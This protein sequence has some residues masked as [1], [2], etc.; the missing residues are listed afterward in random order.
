MKIN[1]TIKR[2]SLMFVCFS[3]IVFWIIGLQ[4]M[5][6]EPS[7]RASIMTIDEVVEDIPEIKNGQYDDEI[8]PKLDTNKIDSS[9]E[10]AK[11]LISEAAHSEYE[12]AN[13]ILQ[14]SITNIK[15]N[16]KKSLDRMLK[17]YLGISE[18]DAKSIEDEVYQR[19]QSSI[20]NT[21][22]EEVESYLQSAEWNLEATV[23]SEKDEKTLDQNDIE[24]DLNWESVYFVDY[25][26]NKVDDLEKDLQGSIHERIKSIEKQVIKS[27]VGKEVSDYQLEKSE[28]ETHVSDLQETIY[29]S[30]NKEESSM[31]KQVS[32]IENKWEEKITS[33]LE[34]FLIGKKGVS[35]EDMEEIKE[36]IHYQLQDQIDFA[37]SDET[38]MLEDIVDEKLIEL[39]DAADEDR[40]IVERAKMLGMVESDEKKSDNVDFI[41]KDLDGRTEEFVLS[42]KNSIEQMKN[43]LVVSLASLTEDIERR[44]FKEVGVD[45]SEDEIE[46]L[47]EKEMNNMEILIDI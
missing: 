13:E 2:V 35:K 15:Q 11:R 47:L 43:D 40:L 17:M 46:S 27:K 41:E 12:E 7:L 18:E 33:V 26:K 1:F 28:I 32:E 14:N 45:L 31:Y 9:L 24:K 16:M 6:V 36:K 37:L 22:E 44:I 29:Q 21:F 3:I 23:Q 4:I 39:D 20:Q 34:E 25:L 8:S 10:K 42:I 5:T 38:L 19:L 30:A